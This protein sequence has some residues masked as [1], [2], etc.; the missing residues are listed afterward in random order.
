MPTIYNFEAKSIQNYILDSSKLKDMI[1]ASEQIEYMCCDNGLLDEVLYSLDL[2]TKVQFARRAGGAFIAIFANLAD[3]KRFQAVWTFWVQQALPGLGFA[4]GIGTD[5]SL[6]IAIKMAQQA[7]FEDKHN[8]FFSTLPLAGPLVARSPRTGQPAVSRIEKLNER[9]DATTEGKR[10]FRNGKL[11]IA[12]LRFDTPVDWPI[13]LNNK[14]KE[15]H[16]E[17]TFPLLDDNNYIAIVHAD[18]NNLGQLLK[19]L[20]EELT[21]NQYIQT[22]TAFSHAIE[23]AT[24]ESAIEAII[25][26]SK[27]ATR[28]E[29]MPGRPLVL[30][31]DDFTFIVRGD[32]ALDFTKVFLEEF[33]KRSND[34]LT[35]L[36]ANHPAL[37]DLPTQLTAAA[38][39]A[40]VKVSQPFYQGYD[41]A[42]SL[43]KYAKK[44]SKEHIGKTK[45]VP[46]SLA[47]HR[48]SSNNIDKYE[49]VIEHE[50]TIGNNF[51]L[52]MQPYFIKPS[53][54]CHECPDLKDLQELLILLNKPEVSHGTLREFL[55]LLEINKLQA[56]AAIQRWYDNLK[57][58]GK[59]KLLERFEHLLED[60]IKEPYKHFASPI[61]L[62]DNQKRTPIGDALVLLQ[63]SK[64]SNYVSSDI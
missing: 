34:E 6:K 15:G 26:I 52:S 60:L 12:K 2:F 4:Q 16:E 38:G 20:A 25:P 24:L 35:K 17:K 39:I 51:L 7:L 50:L 33:E 9:V 42:E 8:V 29:I 18:A 5:A 45:L 46:S 32:L 1:G 48:M 3:A 55:S 61:R 37:K 21:D 63:I 47:F 54:Q 44:I 62:I 57:N 56:E 59:V 41:L 10:K 14:D 36:K 28:F 40:Y 22:L 11:L 19:T 53:T 43:C 31:G 13:N 27:E 30:G 23:S 49:T 58:R 64:G